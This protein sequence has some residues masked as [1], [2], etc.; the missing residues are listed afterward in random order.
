MKT[1][2]AVLVSSIIIFASGCEKTTMNTNESE[3]EIVVSTDK[4]VYSSGEKI[5][6]EVLNKT[7]NEWNHFKC[8][9]VNIAPDKISKFHSG[10]WL[11]FDYFVICTTMGPAGYFALIEPMEMIKD[12]LMIEEIG[13]YKLRF[14]FIAGSDT[15]FYYSN[16]F[17][18]IE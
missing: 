11:E 8:D 15:L 10:I 13:K 4:K 14:K 5:A 12:T 2:N 7:K 6:I 16:E 17:E 3:K 1:L 9:N 18:I